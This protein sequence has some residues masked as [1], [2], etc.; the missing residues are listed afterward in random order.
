MEKIKF[1][2][3]QQM[4][5]MK[6]TAN[7]IVKLQKTKKEMEWQHRYSHGMPKIA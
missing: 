2:D 1:H 6:P 4:L 3:E 7:D 5:L